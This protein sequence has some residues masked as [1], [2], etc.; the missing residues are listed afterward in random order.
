QSMARD[1]PPPLK[2]RGFCRTHVLT[3]ALRRWQRDYVTRHGCVPPGSTQDVDCGIVVPVE[4]QATGAYDPTG[5]KVEVLEHR[6][7]LRATA[8]RVGRVYEGH[9]T[10]SAFSLVREVVSERRP[11]AIQNA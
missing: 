5:R 1:T 8:R 3:V 2:W 6:T 10:T 11:A 7:T 4:R 9:L